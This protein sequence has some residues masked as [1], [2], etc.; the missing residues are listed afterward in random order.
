MEVDEAGADKLQ[1]YET[2]VKS[3]CDSNQPPNGNNIKILDELIR[4][5]DTPDDPVYQGNCLQLVADLACSQKALTF[6]EERQVP[7]KLLH[8]LAQEDTLIIPHALKLFYTIDSP[9]FETKYKRVLDIIFDYCQ[10]D[11][12]QLLYYAVDFI[13]ALGRRG[14]KGRVVLDKHPQFQQKC[15]SKLGST[16]ISSES[17]LKCRTLEC[18]RDLLALEEND[19]IDNA[20]KLS[21]KFYNSIIEGEHKMTNQLL[22]LCRV[23]FKEI[24][25]AAT[26]VVKAISDYTWGQQELASQPDLLKFIKL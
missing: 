1:Q 13:A 6:L 25:T 4:D 9:Q 24:S 3:V 22:I 2:V 10:S 16:I 19:P 8:I 15:L 7:D 23:P 21:E 11:N 14:Y 20:S 12:R 26:L 18:I 17:L 5:I